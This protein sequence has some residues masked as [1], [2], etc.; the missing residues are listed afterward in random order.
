MAIHLEECSICIE[1]IPKRS[2]SRKH[3]QQQ[4]HQHVINDVV[5]VVPDIDDNGS[6]M[7][8]VE[9][10]NIN[11]NNN[12]SNSNIYSYN[13][14]KTFDNTSISSK[15][16]VKSISGG[17]NDA[18]KCTQ[19][20][21]VFCRPCLLLWVKKNKSCPVCRVELT[22]YQVCYLDRYYRQSGELIVYIYN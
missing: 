10:D 18:V 17:S 1:A 13:K 6:D 12:N 22:V 9:R 16:S 4:H 15:R 21:A 14:I 2:K 19:C 11:S 5:E 7:V 20:N 3:H 8:H